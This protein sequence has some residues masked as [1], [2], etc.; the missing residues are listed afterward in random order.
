MTTAHKTIQQVKEAIRQ[1]YAWPG[2]YPIYTVLADGELLC[3]ECAR[4]EFRQIVRATYTNDRGGW[5]AAGADVLWESE[6]PELCAHCNKE[7][8]PAYS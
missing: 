4:A 5:A 6:S 1:P 3:C 2:G 7:L 8:Q